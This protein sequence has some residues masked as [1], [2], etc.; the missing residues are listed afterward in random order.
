MKVFTTQVLEPEGVAILTRVAEV[1]SPPHRN[2]LKREEFLSGIA[3][4][5]GVILIWHTDIMDREAFDHAPKL[6]VVVRRGV[7]YDNIDVAEATRRG[8]CVAV[9]PA[10]IPTIADVAFGLIMCAA[11]KFP[12]ADHFVRMGQW[13]EGGG[14]VAYKFM[15]QDVHH[16]SLGIIGL[17]RIGQEVAKRAL[18]FDMKVMYY[19]QIRRPEVEAKM[20]VTFMLLE[21]LLALSDFISI[22]CAL[23]ESTYHLI[24][25]HTIS[26]MKKTAILVNTSRGPTVDLE[27]LYRALKGG[28]LAGAGLDVFEP[29]PI[30]V[31]HPIL[32]LKNVVFTP[33]LG[34]STMGVRILMAE[35]AARSAAS[36]LL[37][38]EPEYLLNPDVRMARP[39]RPRSTK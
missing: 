22:N 10:N 11:R 38:E 33:H 6:K 15:G 12:Q 30:P 26:L 36:V 20:D 5:D 7:G 16:S 39:L 34:S 2:P 18:G 21:E 24:N 19:D 37:G 31:D 27:A 29:E 8:V 28:Q 25:D 14:W 32:K 9:C 13:K 17:G 23:N 3:D 4:A 35:Q 1:V